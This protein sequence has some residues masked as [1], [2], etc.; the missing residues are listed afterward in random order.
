MCVL[1]DINYKYYTYIYIW[2][3]VFYIN[4]KI[5]IYHI[6]LKKSKYFINISI[7]YKYII[8]D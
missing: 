2:M 5:C 3:C 7:Q 4:I 8:L 6:I 1:N